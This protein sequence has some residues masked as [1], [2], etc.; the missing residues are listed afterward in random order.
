MI[1]SRYISYLHHVVMRNII[2]LMVIVVI[3]LKKDIQIIS[4]HT[5]I[6]LCGSYFEVMK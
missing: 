5:Y 2:Y 4:W 3:Y 6:R 1:I